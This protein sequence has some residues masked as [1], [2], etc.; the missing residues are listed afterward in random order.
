VP[1]EIYENWFKDPE[2]QRIL[3]NT[4]DRFLFNAD[5]TDLN[6]KGGG[7]RWVAAP[8]GEQPTNYTKDHG[9]SHVTL[10]LM[11]SASG[12]PVF[13]FAVVHGSPKQFY[14]GTLTEFVKCYPTFPM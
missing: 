1:L 4:D 6:R 5:E 8:Q 11:V 12:V 7:P 9:S 2:V 14:D 3:K 10:F 13:P